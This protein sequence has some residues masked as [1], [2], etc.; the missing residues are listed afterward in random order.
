MLR[1]DG[2]IIN[3]RQTIVFDLN[4]FFSFLINDDQEYP[5][6]HQKVRMVLIFYSKTVLQYC[7]QF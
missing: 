4:N 2:N 6:R 5:K 3:D 7:T 1:S